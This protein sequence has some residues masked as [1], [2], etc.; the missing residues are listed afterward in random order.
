L[1]RGASGLQGLQEDDTMTWRA[2]AFSLLTPVVAV[3]LAAADS[4]GPADCMAL[5][6]KAD[7]SASGALTQQQAEPYVTDFMSVDTDK[8]GKITHAEFIKGCSAG[9]VR[10]TS[11]S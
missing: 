3:S 5:W 9:F 11:A 2:V 1:E 7:A 4:K 10:R 6:K 8:D